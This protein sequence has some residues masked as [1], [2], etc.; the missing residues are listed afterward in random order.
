FLRIHDTQALF[1]I[2]DFPM[3]STTIK[4]IFEGSKLSKFLPAVSKHDIQTK[5]LLEAFKNMETAPE[6]WKKM[7]DLIGLKPGHVA[8]LRRA[9]SEVQDA[10]KE[11]ERKALESKLACSYIIEAKVGY[12]GSS[13]GRW[14]TALRVSFG[15]HSREFVFHPGYT[16]PPGA[17]RI[18]GIFSNRS[19]GFVPDAKEFYSFN[20]VLNSNGNHKISIK[21]PRPEQSKK[22][23]SASFSDSKLFHPKEFPT[24]GFGHQLNN[25]NAKVKIPMECTPNAYG[26]HK[27]V[28][29]SITKLSPNDRDN[30][31]GEVKAK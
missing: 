8:R 16:S 5:S 9:L 15:S 20:I 28:L 27:M 23:F 7:I 2:L 21:D 14:G 13:F 1:C 4:E 25:M 24:V 18:N 19:M 17:F 31:K 6:Q 29:E 30:S 26:T 12:W 3:S 11:E 10:I 22:E